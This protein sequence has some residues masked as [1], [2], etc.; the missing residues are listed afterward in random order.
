MGLDL[1]ANKDQDLSLVNPGDTITYTIIFANLVS[2]TLPLTSAFFVDTIPA[3]TS[4]VLDSVTIDGNSIPGDPSVGPGIPLGP[5]GIAQG[6]L[7]KFQ[8]RV[9]ATAPV[10]APISNYATINYTA[11]DGTQEISDRIQ[12]N[13]VTATV[14]SQPV[15][16][17]SALRSSI[18][19]GQTNTYTITIDNS[20]STL[21]MTNVYLSDVLQ[22]G[23]SYVAGSTVIG[24]NAPVDANPSVGQG[25]FIGTIAGGA[26]LTVSFQVKIDSL[27]NPNPLLNQAAVT[28]TIN[29]QPKT[30]PSNKIEV[31]VVTAREQAI[32]DIIES[33]ALEQAALSHILNA[34]G[35]KLQKIIQLSVGTNQLL[36]ANKSVSSMVSS[37]SMLEMG[38]QSKLNLFSNCLC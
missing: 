34:E 33:V 27:P 32:T 30:L 37:V 6:F 17:K 20:L 36:A 18:V 23:T 31:R 11:H 1:F 2:S 28:A 21:P 25:V 38:L 7:I 16:T 4:F 35:E 5:V 26:T 3:N 10:N 8:V 9:N 14:I 24:T 29:T 12:T 13:V 22:S 19:I 15:I